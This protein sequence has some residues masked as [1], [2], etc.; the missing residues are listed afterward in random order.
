M[1][2]WRLKVKFFFVGSSYSHATILSSS[3]I[4]G[5]SP[6]FAKQGHSLRL[7]LTQSTPEYLCIRC[8]IQPIVYPIIVEATIKPI[9]LELIPRWD[10]MDHLHVGLRST[11]TN[12][13][14]C[15]VM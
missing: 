7:F 6:N 1:N 15:W 2:T 14:N 3:N 9:Y 11:S 12:K 8:A 13:S 5:H 4:S 10:V